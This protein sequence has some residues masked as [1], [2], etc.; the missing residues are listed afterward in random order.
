MGMNA[1]KLQNFIKMK[2]FASNLSTNGW[3]STNWRAL[4]ETKRGK[5]KK[6][7]WKKKMMR[8][9]KRKK[10]KALMM[11]DSNKNIMQCCKYLTSKLEKRM[12]RK[13]NLQFDFN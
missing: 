9:V 7:K 11:R 5:D 6:S 13:H 10:C 1:N 2:R 12:R 8:K 4:R 3:K